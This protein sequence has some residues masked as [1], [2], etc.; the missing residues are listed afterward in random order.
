M[1]RLGLEFRPSAS[2]VCLLRRVMRADMG[3]RV[4]FFFFLLTVLVSELG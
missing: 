3:K 2:G 1:F 4:F